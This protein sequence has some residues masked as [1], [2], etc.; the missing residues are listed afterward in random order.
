M[1]ARPYT[2]EE[3]ATIER[4]YPW[5]KYSVATGHVA[6][7]GW[8]EEAR[9]AFHRSHCYRV[10][11][12]VPTSQ[13]G[14]YGWRSETRLFETEAEARAVAEAPMGIASSVTLDVSN[15]GWANYK[16]DARVTKL[17]SR[18]NSN[19]KKGKGKR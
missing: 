7:G 16:P 5:S 9:V 17:Y 19:L 6:P 12:I 13:P 14:C 11:W 3:I 10:T 18:K 4:R 1:Q 2:P 8:D 15:N